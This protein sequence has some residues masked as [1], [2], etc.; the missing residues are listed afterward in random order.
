[1]TMIDSRTRLDT[2]LTELKGL[3]DLHDRQAIVTRLGAIESRIKEATRQ[4]TQ[5]TLAIQGLQSIAGTGAGSTDSGDRRKLEE[6]AQ[7]LLELI[8]SGKVT[9]TSRRDEVL[10]TNIAEGAERMYKSASAKWAGYFSER[11]DVYKKLSDA[12]SD[13]G[14]PGGSDL[15]DAVV[16]LSRLKQTLPSA[17]D[18]VDAAS[19]ALDTA[20]AAIEDL[21][22]EGEAGR[23]LVAAVRGEAT[24]NM[25]KTE[26]VQRFLSAYPALIPMLRVRLA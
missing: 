14:L 9:T 19:A 21:G 11:A 16:V 23:F 10:T 13:A 18:S 2:L 26:D 24:L 7:S 3:P 22:L 8:E 6:A 17:R 4:V 5:A 20:R 15:A 1:M 25:V 12:A